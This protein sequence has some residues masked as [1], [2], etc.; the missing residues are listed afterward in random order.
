[1]PTPAPMT[2]KTLATIKAMSQSQEA[3]TIADALGWDL[4]RLCRVARAH[5]IELLNANPMLERTAETPQRSS[6]RPPIP[7][8]SPLEQVIASLRPSQRELVMVL[9]TASGGRFIS[10]AEISSRLGIKSDRFW[11]TIARINARLAECGYKIEGCAG[12]NGGYRLVAIEPEQTN[13]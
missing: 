2:P 11:R 6:P 13:N 8:A 12:N 4:N 7:Q 9:R 1:M 3:P 5:S 10:G